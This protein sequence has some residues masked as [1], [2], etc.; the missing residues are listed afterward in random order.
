MIRSIS[1]RSR[2][3]SMSKTWIPESVAKMWPSWPG[4]GP[5][6]PDRCH[7]YTPFDLLKWPTYQSHHPSRTAHTQWHLP[8][9]ALLVALAYI[10]Q[11]VPS[12]SRWAEDERLYNRPSPFSVIERV[13]QHCM[14]GRY[15][16]WLAPNE[17]DT[18][19]QDLGYTWYAR[20]YWEAA[21]WR[22]GTWWLDRQLWEWR[23]VSDDGAQ[24]R[25]CSLVMTDEPRQPK[26]EVIHPISIAFV[27]KEPFS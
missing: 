18:P 4:W 22:L 15:V 27:K 1:A 3:S 23:D 9:Q 25:I 8:G 14:W 13:D 11:W 5:K 19:C 21:R 26:V 24:R 6:V 10:R 20:T 17:G 12:K 16:R 7:L 2:A